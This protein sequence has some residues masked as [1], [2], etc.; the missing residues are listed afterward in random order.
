MSVSFILHPNVNILDQFQTSADAI[1][2]VKDHSIRSMLVTNTKKKVVGLASET[3]ILYRVYLHN[4]LARVV[5]EEIV[6]T[7][8]IFIPPDT[9]ISDALSVIAKHVIRQIV[10]Y[11]GNTVFELITSDD[12]IVKME[13]ALV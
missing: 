2:L 4:P 12:I 8:I 10:V 13:K 3:D 5:L 7:P 1:K 9:A 11:S 6:S